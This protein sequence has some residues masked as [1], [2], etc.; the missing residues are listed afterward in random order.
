MYTELLENIII[1]Y[2]FENASIDNKII[3]FDNDH[4]F[5]SFFVVDCFDVRFCQNYS[6]IAIYF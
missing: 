5:N 2:V 4:L 1:S 6:K 3:R